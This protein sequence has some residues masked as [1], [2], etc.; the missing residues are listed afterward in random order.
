M[1][2]T[3]LIGNG[4]DLNLGLKTAYPEFINWYTDGFANDSDTIKSFKESIADNCVLWSSA[5][6]AFG[7]YT[8]KYLNIG[9]EKFCEC[10]E[11]FC[12]KLALYLEEEESNIDFDEKREIIIKSFSNS[13]N[14]EKI[15]SHFSEVQRTQLFNALSSLGNE[16]NYNFIDFNYTSTLD[17]CIDAVKSVDGILGKRRVNSTVFTHKISSLYHVHGYTYRDMVLGVNDETQLRAP[18]LFK[19]VGEEYKSQIIKRET[20]IMNEENVDQKVADLISTSE[21]MY[22]YGM[23][24]GET[25]AIWWQ[26]I[27]AAMQKTEALHV[28]IHCFDAPR[29][30][31]I[32]RKLQS[33]A[34][35]VKKQFLSYSNIN[36]KEYDN[37]AGR[38]HIDSGNIFLAMEGLAKQ[39]KIDVKSVG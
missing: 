1:T 39:N 25:D 32:H 10:H 4:F 15:I 8:E 34:K 36:E 7:E 37:L 9:A 24:L 11:D 18:E 14:I 35:R 13:I 31:L 5:E 19:N 3:F 26:R 33:Y 17:K 21:M 6:K 16:Y 20:N 27:V 38:I 23:S 29:D 22:I 28:M 30:A 2:I 12:E